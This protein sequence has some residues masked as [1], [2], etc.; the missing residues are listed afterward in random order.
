M[1][2]NLQGSNTTLPNF[3]F[4]GVCSVCHQ[5]I[6]PQYYFCPNCGAKINTAPLSTTPQTQAWIY[7]FSIILPLI[8][9]LFITRWPG[10][11]YYKSKD[12][13]TH[14]IG[15]IAWALIIISSLVTI[16]LAWYWTQQMIQSQI[17]SINTDFSGI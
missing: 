15:Q 10:V 11:K 3:S 7:L 2:Q 16:G 17:Q 13:K 4:S 8:A 12:P 14:R 1:E 9:F 6:L 5:P